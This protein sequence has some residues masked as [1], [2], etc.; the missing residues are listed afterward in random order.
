M[1]K[2]PLT[3]GKY[4]LV[5][6]KDFEE[7]SKFK[8][9]FNSGYVVRSGYK[10]GKRFRLRMHRVILKAKIGEVCDHINGNALDNRCTNLRI[11]LQSE[12]MRNR[13]KNG[14]NTSGVKGIYWD[15]ESNSWRAQIQVNGKKISIGRFSNLKNARVAYREVARKV[16][17]N[18]ARLK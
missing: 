3:Q 12:N 18:F 7:L 4:A 8:W 5:D 17:G 9:Y 14:N 6:D 16:H 1:K 11:C 2:I 13:K 10:N 15:K